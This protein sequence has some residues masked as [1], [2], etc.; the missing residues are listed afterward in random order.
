MTA[1]GRRTTTTTRCGWSPGHGEAAAD[2][3]GTGRTVRP[4]GCRREPVVLPSLSASR[5]SRGT[6]LVVRRFGFWWRRSSPLPPGPRRG[7][8]GRGRRRSARWLCDQR[9]GGVAVQRA[10]GELAQSRPSARS[11]PVRCAGFMSGRAPLPTNHRR[12]HCQWRHS[13]WLIKPQRAVT[14]GPSGT[15]PTLRG[16]DKGNVALGG[17]CHAGDVG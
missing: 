10:R 14:P 8:G 2:G 1:V 6:T 12:H 11:G 4:P 13:Y 3:S 7:P 15:G 5:P 16:I 17:E 9:P